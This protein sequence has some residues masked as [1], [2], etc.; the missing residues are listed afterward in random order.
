MNKRGKDF[1]D[2][3][4]CTKRSLLNGCT[5]GDVLG[6]FTYAGP[7]GKSVVDYAATSK[8]LKNSVNLFKVLDLTKFSD[9]KPC[10]CS[11][12][13]EGSFMSGDEIM[14]KFEDVPRR[15]K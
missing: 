3:L 6:E 13:L 8:N 1:I 10:V 2:F 14:E 15:Y 11:L 4:A 5:I 7:N 12:N 9:H